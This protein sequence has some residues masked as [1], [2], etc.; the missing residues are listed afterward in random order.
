MVNLPAFDVAYYDNIP[1]PHTFALIAFG[2]GIIACFRWRFRALRHKSFDRMNSQARLL[3]LFLLLG[4]PLGAAAQ[5]TMYF[6]AHLTGDI[7]LDGNAT[8]SLTTNYLSYNVKTPFGW[9]SAQLRAPWPDPNAPALF[10]LNLYYCDP[11][12]PLPSTNIGGCFFQGHFLLSDAEIS[13]LKGGGWFISSA[14]PSAPPSYGIAGQILG[15]PEPHDALLFGEGLALA[16]FGSW[17]RQ[18]RAPGIPHGHPEA[19]KKE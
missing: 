2:S 7:I 9:D 5:G 17:R 6:E 19:I 12:H 18:M 3:L 14:P 15:V 11:P 1:E 8:F 10:N 4:L 16:L 13:D